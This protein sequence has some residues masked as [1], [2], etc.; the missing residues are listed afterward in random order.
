[1]AAKIGERMTGDRAFLFGRRTYAAYR[2]R[3]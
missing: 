1:M 3:R 2:R